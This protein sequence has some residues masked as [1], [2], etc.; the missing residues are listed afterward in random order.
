[1]L[2]AAGEIVLRLREGIAPV[3]R[4]GGEDL[5]EVGPVGRAGVAHLVDAK[6]QRIVSAHGAER[7]LGPVVR[8]GVVDVGDP[9]NAP[10]L[11][12]LPINPRCDRRLQ[13]G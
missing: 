7:D 10:A 5:V 8:Q 9:I 1:V 3:R 4:K 13:L 12:A 6:G 11:G 2:L